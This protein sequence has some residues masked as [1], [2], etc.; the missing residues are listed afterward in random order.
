MNDNEIKIYKK[1]GIKQQN[2]M[3]EEKNKLEIKKIKIK[4]NCT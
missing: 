3:R 1:Y 4:N 2:T